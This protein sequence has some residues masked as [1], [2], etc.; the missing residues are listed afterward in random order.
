[1]TVARLEY[2]FPR[3]AATR[4]LP[5]SGARSSRRL[6]LLIAMRIAFARRAQGELNELR[7]LA[8]IVPDQPLQ[9]PDPMLIRAVPHRTAS[10]ESRPHL[11]DGRHCRG[12]EARY[13]RRRRLLNSQHLPV[14]CPTDRKGINIQDN[15][16]RSSF[17]DRGEELRILDAGHRRFP[18]DC[19]SAQISRRLVISGSDTSTR[20]GT[21]MVW[22]S[23]KVTSWE[24][25]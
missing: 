3:L 22:S 10:R 23:V 4:Y 13:D 9:W 18:L 17:V 5:F 15:N 20:R 11:S 25:R 1:L 6:R 24:L 12:I 14:E 16:V 21:S 19:N 2:S 8:Q 7:V